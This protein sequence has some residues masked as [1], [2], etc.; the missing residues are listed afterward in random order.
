MSDRNAEVEVETCAGKVDVH[1]CVDDRLV[2]AAD[3][4]RPMK[5]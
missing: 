5:S 2:A 4:K 3:I 1:D